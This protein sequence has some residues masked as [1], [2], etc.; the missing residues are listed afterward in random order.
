[1]ILRLVRRTGGARCRAASAPPRELGAAGDSTGVGANTRELG[2][3]R[4]DDGGGTTEVF[5]D[6]GIESEDLQDVD[7]LLRSRMAGEISQMTFWDEIKRRSLLSDDFDPKTEVD[8]LDIESGGSVN[9]SG[10]GEDAE[11]D[12]LPGTAT[13]RRNQAGDVTSETKEHYHVL[14]AN[15]ETSVETD[16][17]TGETHFH[18]WDELGIRTSVDDAHSHILLVRAAAGSHVGAEKPAPEEDEDVNSSEGISPQSA[19]AAG[20]SQQVNSISGQ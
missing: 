8:L 19:Q 7:L 2:V 6:F 14:Q 10:S 9:E 16:P 3:A 20:S 5:K 12:E 17:E 11:D 4:L 1:M 18:T 15:G 13:E